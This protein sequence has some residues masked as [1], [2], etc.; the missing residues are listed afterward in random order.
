MGD[1]VYVWWWIR[2][3]NLWYTDWK[4]NSYVWVL[5]RVPKMCISSLSKKFSG[6]S[7]LFFFNINELKFILRIVLSMFFRI[8]WTPPQINQE[9][10]VKC[11]PKS[12]SRFSFL[13][14]KDLLL[15]E[16]FSHPKQLENKTQCKKQWFSEDRQ[17]SVTPERRERNE[18][19]LMTAT[20]YAWGSL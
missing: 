16:L 18:L 1:R 5:L 15:Q 20:V 8:W 13:P 17:R 7:F 14:I 9:D 2:W 10:T 19:C 12:T 3:Y 6:F 11:Q 4:Q